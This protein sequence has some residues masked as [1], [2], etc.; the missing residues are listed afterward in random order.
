[1]RVFRIFVSHALIVFAAE[2]DAHDNR[3][4][5]EMLWAVFQIHHKRSRFV[6]DMFYRKKRISRELYEFCLR[7]KYA[8]A[9][10]IAK[11][12]KVRLR[13]STLRHEFPLLWVPVFGF[14]SL[15]TLSFQSCFF[16][17]LLRLL[18]CIFLNL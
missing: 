15:L 2:S 17:V 11:W 7:E 12:K 13:F 8:D 3:R 16:P 18:H 10:L 14:G 1:M 6:Y 4:K 9:A 5:N